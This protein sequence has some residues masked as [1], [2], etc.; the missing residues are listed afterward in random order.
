MV[1]A[2]GYRQL[3][4]VWRLVALADVA[5]GERGWG[6]LER[7]GFGAPLPVPVVPAPL[8]APVAQP[9]APR[10]DL[11]E[12][13]VDERARAVP[14]RAQEWRYTLTYLRGYAGLDG[15][16]PRSFDDLVRDV[17]SELLEPAPA[18]A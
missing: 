17:F 8:P 11:L 18:A 9:R 10:I 6:K 16:L 12:R 15:R 2:L 3:N 14:D 13:L 1:D 5:R 7:R 4:E